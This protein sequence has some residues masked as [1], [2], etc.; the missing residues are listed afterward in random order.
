MALVWMTCCGHE[1]VG[2]DR[3]HCCAR[4]RF[5]GCGQVFDDAD[6]FDAHR[7][8]DDCVDPRTLGLVQTRNGIWLRALDLLPAS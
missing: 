1:W 7:N 6:L 8:N 4:D 2:V 5:A 3:A